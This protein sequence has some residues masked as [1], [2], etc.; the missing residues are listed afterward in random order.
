MPC[1]T[2]QPS[3]TREKWLEHMLCQA[4]RFLNKEQI[5]SVEGLDIYQDLYDWYGNHLLQDF[6]HNHK[7]DVEN[8]SEI[9][10]YVKEAARIGIRLFLDKGGNC[11]SEPLNNIVPKMKY[12]IKC[13]EKNNA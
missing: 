4:C 3:C 8:K 12:D 1:N 7:I 2:E 11:S 5:M 10:K 9:E 13:E 6:Y